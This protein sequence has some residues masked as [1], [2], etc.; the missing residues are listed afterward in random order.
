VSE[1]GETPGDV[2]LAWLL[3]QPAVTATIVGPRTADQLTRSLR[4]RRSLWAR[5]R[6]A[7][8]TRSGLAP[9]A[10][11]RRRTPG[12]SLFPTS[13]AITPAELSRRHR[14]RALSRS[15]EQ[16]GEPA[17]GPCP[18]HARGQGRTGVS[19]IITIGSGGQLISSDNPFGRPNTEVAVRDMRLNHFNLAG[20]VDDVR[21]LVGPLTCGGS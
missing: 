10:R 18:A 16:R 1:L 20:Q 7:C 17:G 2:A 9:A 5:R 3:H 19:D 12:E 15:V 6:C 11:P 4:A 21:K 13:A 8:S 14:S